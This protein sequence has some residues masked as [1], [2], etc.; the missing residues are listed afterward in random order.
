TV[1]VLIVDKINIIEDVTFLDYIRN[2]TQ[3]HFAVAV[4]FTETNGHYTDPNSLHHF[5]A[6]H[7]NPYEIAIKSVGEIIQNYDQSQIFPAF[8]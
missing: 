7:L 4:D 3:L 5:C 6:T 2:G 8:G 1:G